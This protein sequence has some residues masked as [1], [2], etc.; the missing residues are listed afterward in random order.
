[1]H[2][3]LRITEAHSFFLDNNLTD[4]AQDYTTE[5]IDLITNVTCKEGLFLDEHIGIC[6]PLCGE[7]LARNVFFQ[8]IAISVGFILSLLVFLM[9]LPVQRKNM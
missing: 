5:S 2:V 9:V 8:R 6:K 4:E 7:F 3:H 1:M